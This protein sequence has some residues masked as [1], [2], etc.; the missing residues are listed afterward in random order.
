MFPLVALLVLLAT[1]TPMS[2]PL[3]EI[4]AT[5]STITLNQVQA[6]MVGM[7][8]FYAGSDK[9]GTKRPHIV[10]KPSSE[11]P[12]NDPFLHYA[13]LG[14]SGEP[15]IWRAADASAFTRMP[16]ETY[17]ATFA[18][19]AADTGAAGSEWKKLYDQLGTIRFER[20]ALRAFVLQSD[21]QK[22]KSLDDI[23][24]IE[25]NVHLRAMR[26]DVYATLKRRHLVAY[27]PA[28]NPGQPTRDPQHAGCSYIATKERANWPYF[29]EPIPKAD[30]ACNTVPRTFVPSP[31]AYVQFPMGFNLWCGTAILMTLRFDLHDKLSAIQ[32]SQV[33]T[34]CM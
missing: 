29:R 4:D 7:Y 16:K 5:A 3:D 14:P 22:K 15:V 31:P 13:G 24:W 18:A 19:V 10:S 11:M 27:N 34:T 2:S 9:R 30:G 28:Y 23:A 6:L 17:E 1:P 26:H 25:S 21:A 8:S 20:L 32:H 33:G 12:A